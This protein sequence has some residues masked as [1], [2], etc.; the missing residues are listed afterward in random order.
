MEQQVLKDSLAISLS[1]SLSLSL[2]LSLS[3]EFSFLYL[4]CERFS[5]RLIS[6][7]CLFLRNAVTVKSYLMQGGLI[8]MPILVRN[9]SQYLKELS[10]RTL[11]HLLPQVRRVKNQRKLKT[12]ISCLFPSTQ[13]P[14]R[15]LNMGV[16]LFITSSPPCQVLFIAITKIFC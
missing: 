13:R 1:F 3:P 6:K 2:S 15:P 12:H 11:F 7:K 9:K 8:E 4:L 10:F 5:C 14:Q 16:T